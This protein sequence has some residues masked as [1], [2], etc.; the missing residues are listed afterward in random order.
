MQSTTVRLTVFLAVA[1]VAAVTL[2]SPARA[3]TY[4]PYPAKLT[5]KSELRFKANLVRDNVK[6]GPR[7]VFFGGSRSQRFDPVYARKKLGL[8]A[9]N[10]AL[11]NGRPEA[12]WAYLNWFY[13]KWPNK[14]IRWVWGMQ[15]TMLRDRDLDPALLQDSRFY[16]Y[17][18]DRPDLLKAQRARLPKTVTGMPKS[19]GF[20]RCTYSSRGL[21]VRNVYDIKRDNGYP[22]S[23]SLDKYIAN[24]L[25][26][27]KGDEAWV[28]D[29]RAREYFEKTVKLLNDHG[30]TP[31]VV[32][33]PVH[34]RVLKVLKQKGLDGDRKRLLEYLRAVEAGDPENPDGNLKIIV[35]DFTQISSFGGKA[36][37]FYDGVHI[38]RGNAHLVIDQ[39]KRK[40]NKYLK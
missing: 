16:R 3:A 21:L 13:S 19:Y 36:D 27:A 14:K 39:I 26:T 28:P 11:S 10:L 24:M 40:A 15:N 32:L 38:T 35:L 2:A 37:R 31:V 20:T 30:T 18:K 33:M 4:P 25:R 8:S 9:V 7:L 6:S 22:L 12:A 29:T 23:K 1:A 5:L 34:P 17:F